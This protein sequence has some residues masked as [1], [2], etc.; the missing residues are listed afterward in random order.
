VHDLKLTVPA[1]ATAGQAFSAAVTAE[2]AQGNP[3]A[4]YSG[5]V[6][7]STSDTSSGVRL[8]ADSTLTNGQGSFSVTLDR[9]GAQ[10]LTVSD[11]A[12]GLTTTMPVTVIAAPANH[13]ALAGPATATAGTGFSFTVTALDQF[14]N[15][16]ANYG[17]SVH[18]AST[19][20]SAGVVL[21]RNSTLTNGQGTFSATLDRAGSQTITGSDSARPSIAGSL[22]VS[23]KA[24][25]A[26]SLS[27]AV[28]ATAVV[29]QPFNA[30]VTALD[31]FGNVAN[32]YI[33]IV[34][35][36][37]SDTLA[38]QLGKL[39]ADYQFTSGDAGA[40]TFSVTLMTA[41]NQTITV[42][43]T[44]GSMSTTSSPITVT[45]I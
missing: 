43:D 31:R 45:V 3:V 17:G 9:A 42:S 25:A 33:G 41:G 11:A 44:S 34:H 5:T 14:G 28:P 35:F 10:T 20:S 38:Q 4:S 1:T 12:N 40:H 7:F 26:A 22:T 16:D 13:L 39:P 29:N 36:T 2:N 19:D 24:A 37:S 32:G 23:I 21:P 27:L 8:P 30:T 6:H 18:F 15:V